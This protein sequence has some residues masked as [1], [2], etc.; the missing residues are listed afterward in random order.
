MKPTLVV[1]AAGM[2][3][4]YGGLKQLDAV[5]PN[6][7]TVMDYS[8]YDAIRA[9]FGKVVF[10]I[11]KD[12]EKQFKAVVGSR[13]AGKLIVDYAF[14]ELDRLPEG[15]ALPKVRKK[16]WGTGHAVLCCSDVVR[17]PFAVINADDFYGAQSYQLLAD[18]LNQQHTAD[19]CNFCMC[20]FL[21]KNTLS[22]NGPV[23]RGICKTTAGKLTAVTELTKIEPHDNGARNIEPGAECALSG[24]EIISM[25][26]WGFTTGVFAQFEKLFFEFLKNH[27]GQE[28]AEFYIPLAVDIL[29]KSGKATVEVLSS[30]DSWF[31]VTYRADRARVVASIK[32]LVESG[33]Y[34]QQLF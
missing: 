31:G 21:L 34:P 4:R 19:S 5:G 14:Q 1:M 33:C 13:Y 30:R 10:V 17:E 26:M 20:G 23:A 12:I 22:A 11:R 24:E 16:P 29:I 6:D 27:S 7:E 8:I 32:T 9:G 15:V 28:K 25:N 18:F 2:G 3:S